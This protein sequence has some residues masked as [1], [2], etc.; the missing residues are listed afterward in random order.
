MSAAVLSLIP[1]S[2]GEQGSSTGFQTVLLQDWDILLSH[3]L[4]NLSPLLLRRLLAIL[5]GKK[6]PCQSLY[7]M[8]LHK[9][10]APSKGMKTALIPWVAPQNQLHTYESARSQEASPAGSQ[11][12]T[13]APQAFPVAGIAHGRRQQPQNTQNRSDPYLVKSP[14]S[15]KKQ[16]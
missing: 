4:A 6:S 16:P 10:K 12:L 7:S 13:S 5:G 8:G 11:N 1:P 3:V 9:T 14:V 15:H 2:S